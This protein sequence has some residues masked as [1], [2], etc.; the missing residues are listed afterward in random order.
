MWRF[1]VAWCAV[2]CCGVVW[3]NDVVVKCGVVRGVL[4]WCGRCVCVVVGGGVR[5][6][7]GVCDLCVVVGV[8]CG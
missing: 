4:V 7:C 3:W 6:L 8:L 2:L 1:G 5:V